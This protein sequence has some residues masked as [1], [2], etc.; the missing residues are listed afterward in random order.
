M[1]DALLTPAVGGLFWA[2]SAGLI[3]FSAKKINQDKNERIIPLMGVLSAFVFAAQMI[4]FT[5]PG[6]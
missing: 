4:N 1:S 3:A 2:T 5:I 6:T